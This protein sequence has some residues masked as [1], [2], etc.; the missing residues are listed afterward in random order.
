[1][2]NTDKVRELYCLEVKAKTKD[3][4]RGRTKDIKKGNINFNNRREDILGG[5]VE[6]NSRG[7]DEDNKETGDKVSPCDACRHALAI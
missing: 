6:D 7:R 5:G 1:M 2:L 4:E 3:S